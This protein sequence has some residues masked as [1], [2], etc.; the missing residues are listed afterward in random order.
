MSIVLNLSHISWRAS[1]RAITP[2]GS[3]FFFL[4]HQLWSIHLRLN[5]E[6]SQFDFTPDAIGLLAR[7][8]R[9]PRAGPSNGMMA[10][11]QFVED[12]PLPEMLM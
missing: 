5:Q 10:G 2:P 7:F 9:F 12:S 6:S 3:R 4:A 1:R 8:V 11:L